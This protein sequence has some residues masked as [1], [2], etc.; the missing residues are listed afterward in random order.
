[1][2]I[3]TDSNQIKIHY[4]EERPN[5]AD[6]ENPYI[7]SHICTDFKITN[8]MIPEIMFINST[9]IGLDYQNPDNIYMIQLKNLITLEFQDLSTARAYFEIF[10][11]GKDISAINLKEDYPE[12][13][14]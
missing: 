11:S 8:E 1:M 2:I 4:A 9:D 12:L 10:C 3:S 6:V 13:F 7:D 5:L 14:L